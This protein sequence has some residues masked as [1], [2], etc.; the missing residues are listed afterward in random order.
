MA[1]VL[2]ANYLS[3]PLS[4]KCY[5]FWLQKNDGQNAKSCFKTRTVVHKWAPI[6]TN[7][8]HHG[9]RVHYLYFLI[10][11]HCDSDTN[12]LTVKISVYL[13]QQ[14]VVSFCWKTLHFVFKNGASDR[15]TLNQLRQGPQPQWSPSPVITLHLQTSDTINQ[16]AK[17][18]FLFSHF[19]TLMFMFSVHILYY[20]YAIIT[21][22]VWKVAC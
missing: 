2:A 15:G 13:W 6:V 16:T 20:N 22:S 11:R 5:H 4:S 9:C 1:L 12:H 10:F 8:W 18:C 21:I 14:S 17:S 19:V 7:G 3:A